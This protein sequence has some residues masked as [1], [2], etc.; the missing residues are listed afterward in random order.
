[1]NTAW[2]ANPRANLVWF[3]AGVA[4]AVVLGQ[5]SWIGF[6]AGGAI[7]G[8]GQRSLRRGVFAGFLLGVAS[9]GVFVG[10]LAGHGALSVA[11]GTGQVLYV[12]LAIPL[13]YATLGG[14]VRGIR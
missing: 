3:L 4:V 13:A 7:A 14:L 11:L 5:L 12:A 2:R 1:M 9:L 10:L 8:F 6:L